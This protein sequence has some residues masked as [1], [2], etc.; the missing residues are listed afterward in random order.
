MPPLSDGPPFSFSDALILYKKEYIASRHPKTVLSREP[1]IILYQNPRFKPLGCRSPRKMDMDLTQPS[2]HAQEYKKSQPLNAKG[3]PSGSSQAD[4]KPDTGTPPS[5][6][7]ET[8]HAWLSWTGCY[9]DGC[10]THKSEKEGA[11]WFPKPPKKERT[12]QLALY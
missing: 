1:S 3:I 9:D 8:P 10:L 4:R 6:V 2:H 5:I 12:K 7:Q 11:G